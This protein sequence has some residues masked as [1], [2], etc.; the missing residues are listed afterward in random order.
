MKVCYLAHVSGKVQG[1]YFRASAQQKAID[2]GLSGYAKN[3]ADGD[4]EVMMCGE[5][6][7]IDQMIEWLHQGPKEAE[8]TKVNCQPVPLKEFNFFSIG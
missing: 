2:L 7:A 6:S 3:L 5:Q 8:V 4:V 1:V